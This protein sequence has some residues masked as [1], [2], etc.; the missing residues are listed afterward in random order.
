M[1]SGQPLTNTAA[2]GPL[3]FIFTVV[4]L[5]LLGVTLLIPVAA[6]IVR[7]YSTDALAVGLL[8]V[9][10]SAAQFLAAPVL[11]RLSDRYGRRPVLLLCLLG[12][13]FGYVLFGIGGAL[14]ILFL[15]R[16]IDG[17]TG[18]N[19][20]VAQAYIA[21]VTP[22]E[23]RARNYALIGAAFGLGFILGPVLGG[24]LS[25]ISL[26]APAYAAGALSL[27]SAIVGFFVLPE[28][29]PP[30]KRS[31]AQLSLADA[32]PLA[33]IAG[34]ARLPGLGPLLLASA[35]FNLAFSGMVSNIAV[36]LI[37]RFAVRPPDIALL[38]TVTGVVNV[39][40][41]GGVVRRIAPRFGERALALAGL[42][43]LAV[44]YLGM[45]FAPALWVFY[46]LTILSAIGNALT[47]P[48]L[49]ALIANQ[50]SP[51]DQGRVAG[52]SAAIGSLMNVAG[53]LWAGATYDYLMPGMP[54]W[55]GA[56]FFICAWLL[57]ARRRS[58]AQPAPE[59]APSPQ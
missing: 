56:I 18:G 31:T 45:A 48:T 50:V 25:Q 26:S 17:I 19:L 39:V 57:I 1:A 13:A 41:Q 34:I 3:A 37:E 28:S 23:E 27:A 2:R 38:L 12:S 58:A 46:P 44:A 52:V 14:W 6:Y 47:I 32:N 40:M 5:D 35:A 11:G 33:A 8:A 59:P 7:E 49:T 36:F 20:S 9:I 16:L 4:L 43:T 15:S 55:S 10:Y 24:T 42:A 54:Y 30:E 29:L 51:Q 21:D 22:P 53:P